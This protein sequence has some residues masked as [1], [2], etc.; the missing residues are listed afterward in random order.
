VF[1][2]VDDDGRLVGMISRGDLLR[3]DSPPT[4]TPTDP[5]SA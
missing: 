1:P 4:T 2:V 3:A 5:P